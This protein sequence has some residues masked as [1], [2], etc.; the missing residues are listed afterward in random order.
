MLQRVANIN[1]FRFEQK[2]QP[3]SI[4]IG[5][6]V[7]T[8]IVTDQQRLA[9]VITN[10]LSNANKFTPHGGHVGVFVRS[11]GESGGFVTLE[12]QVRDEGI[13]MTEAQQARLFRTFEQ[14]EGGN[15][16]RFGGAGLGLSIAKT[17]I[18]KMGGAIR[19]QSAPGKGSAF[20]FTIHAKKATPYA[21]APSAPP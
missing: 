11:P 19:L 21:P 14:A 1:C 4:M 17:I 7:P 16:R 3:L 6:D 18:E 10:L 2:D 20:T 12:F 5:H 8:A 13:G 15:T 9:Q